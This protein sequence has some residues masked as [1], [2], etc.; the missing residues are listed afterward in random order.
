ML[1]VKNEKIRVYKL[2]NIDEKGYVKNLYIYEIN[3]DYYR[4]LWYNEKNRKII[5]INKLHLNN[6][7]F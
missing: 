4:E 7:V 6:E 3:M 5:I 2:R 1:I